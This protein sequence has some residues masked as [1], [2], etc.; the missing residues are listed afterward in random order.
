MNATLSLSR[1]PV[2]RA[3]Q[4]RTPRRILMTADPLGGVWNYVVELCRSWSAA[5]TQILLAT[6][7]AALRP[8]Q[9][10]E[11]KRI[12]GLRLD[13]SQFRLEWMEDAWDD[14]SSAGSWL[15]DLEEQ[16]KPELIHLNHFVHGAL[17][18]QAPVLMTAHSCRLSW[19]EAVKGEP[20][21]AN[22][23]RY[24]HAVAHGLH[25]AQLVIVPN[26][27][28]KDSL[29]Q[30][31]GSLNRVQVIPEG[32]KAADYVCCQPRD[33]FILTTGPLWDEATNLSVLSQAAPALAW[34]IVTAGE[35]RAPGASTSHEWENLNHAGK[36][37]AALL[38]RLMGRASIFA[39]P[40]LYEPSG[41]AA[42]PAALSGC[43]LVLA[44]LPILRETWGECAI[45]ADPHDADAWTQALQR[46]IKDDR[47]R[48]RMADLAGNRALT[49]PMNRMHI[50]Y[51]NA[52]ISLLET[53]RHPAS[54]H[55]V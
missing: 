52:C 5:G 48:R 14:V 41:L 35:T 29:E 17:S 19:W 21:P 6:M 32:R 49:Y 51:Q 45:Y 40:A 46:L 38:K 43:A 37:T 33:P 3:L 30:Y 44:D 34:P 10:E 9:W 25:S 31:Y 8:D 4:G 16:W 36:P 20:A 12:P 50:A 47:A 11:V 1:P 26:L 55:L 13:E 7:G 22:M 39:L 28:I 42:L 2:L 53:A 54:L 18:W 15:L 24:A 27:M 23:E